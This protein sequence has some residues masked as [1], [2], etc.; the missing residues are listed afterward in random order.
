MDEKIFL[1]GNFFKKEDAKIS[2]FDHG[3]LYGDGV[4]EGIRAYNRKVFKLKEH[5]DRLYVGAEIIKLQIPM[6]KAELEDA[7]IKLLLE[8]KL[9]D[10]YI[11]VVVTRG[12]GDLGL[13]P[14]KCKKATVFIIA[15]KI[16]LYPEKYYENGLPIIIAKT[17]RNHPFSINPCV[18]SLNYLNNIF[19]KIEAVEKN[20]E[21]ALMLTIDGFV[22]EC[23]GDNIFI[24]KNG[25]LITPPN[26]IGALNG[27]TQGAVISL[28]KKRNILFSY[29]MMKPEDIYT[30]DECFLTGTA[31]EVIP[32]VAV[33]GKVIGTG[34]P[35]DVTKSLIQD[36]RALV[37]LEGVKY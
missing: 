37:K 26:E 4:F 6:S 5:L 35:G 18:K 32:V 1:D 8:N 16:V 17:R 27:I 34:K 31:A 9:D 15:G 12:V 20:V 7:V 21:E 30:A 23:T 3:L 29:L 33:D 36:F 2:V 19:A 22:C 24:V 14:R 10:A 13:D 28:A 25:K 11:R